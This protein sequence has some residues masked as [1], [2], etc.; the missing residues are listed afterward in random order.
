MIWRHRLHQLIR[1]R[2]Y[3]WYNGIMGNC[4]H[5]VH[6]GLYL[7]TDTCNAYIIKRGDAAIAIDP[8]DGRWIDQL[9]HIGI[10][11]LEWVLLTHSHRD[12]CAGIYR[13][14]RVT[15]KLAVPLLERHLVEDA[16]SFWRSRQLYHNYNQVDDCLSLPRSA[17]VD[18]TLCD[19]ETF[20]WRD[21]RLEVIPTPGHTP[22][23]IALLGEFDGKRIAFV[24]DSIEADGRVPLI[25][26]LQ[27]CYGDASGAAALCNSLHYLK[28]QQPDLLMPARGEPIEQPA[29]ACDA[30]ADRL[31]IFCREMM[32]PIDQLAE[33]G[34]YRLSDHLLASNTGSCSYYAVLDGTGHAVMIDVGYPETTLA[35]PHDYGYRTRFLP[36]GIDALM[37]DHGVT[38]ID[39]VIITHYHDDHVIGVP[40][41]QNRLGSEVCCYD[42]IAPIIERPTDFNMPCLLPVPIRVDRALA[43]REKWQWRGVTFQMHDMPG[44]T[45]LHSGISFDLDGQRWLALGDS[46]H[47]PGGVVSHGHIIFA[48]RV[49]ARNH[50]KVGQRMLEIS[51]NVLLHG[52]HRRQVDGKGRSDLPV[53]RQDLADFL[54]SS[55]RLSGVLADIV[56]DQHE[57][58]CRVDW[59]RIEPYR[60]FLRPG[61]S[62]TI[63]LLAEN[64]HDQDVDLQMRFVLPEGVSVEPDAVTC[65]VPADQTHESEH[66][67]RFDRVTGASPLIV[68]VDTVLDGRPM[69]WVGHGQLW[70]EGTPR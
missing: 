42:R 33:Q 17:P 38:K 25:H 53:T 51:P 60:V 27:Y 2:I 65:R 48:N 55:H 10:N 1:H 62:T 39:A 70:Y 68:C 18:H 30:L 23:S 7:A 44:Q 35:E 22:G 56:V 61:D 58:R 54:E 26:T 14:D 5:E 13:F 36:V 21:V 28:Q 31:R 8:G 67:L 41:L 63:R 47:V 37:R 19:F 24:G 11:R 49:S 12:Q 43:D 3:V 29:A 40:Y 20:E 9:V 45:D 4:L 66:Q 59:V 46:C 34:F 16:E 64:L 57:R 32:M 69:G 6:P 15:T 52:H 50:I